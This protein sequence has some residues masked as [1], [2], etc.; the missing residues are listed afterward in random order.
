MAFC[1]NKLTELI[2]HVVSDNWIQYELMTS[3]VFNVITS[4]RD[5]SLMILV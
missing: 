4:L 1:I 5:L 3:L 2:T